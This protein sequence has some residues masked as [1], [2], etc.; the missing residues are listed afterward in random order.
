MS[1]LDFEAAAQDADTIWPP[2][3]SGTGSAG[4]AAMFRIIADN[5]QAQHR[6]L[7]DAAVAQERAQVAPLLAAV[8]EWQEAQKAPIEAPPFTI[9]W[10]AA[11]EKYRA[12]YNKAKEALAAFPLP[13]TE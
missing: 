12:R 7:L 10:G 2:V 9:G 6:A 11:Y 8:R 1:E 13:R 5:I 3:G 4:H